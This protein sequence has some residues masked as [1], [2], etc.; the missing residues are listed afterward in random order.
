ME[1]G[2]IRNK[3]RF[4]ARYTLL[5]IAVAAPML[6]LLIVSGKTLLWGNDAF[7]QQ[8][9]VL[10][11]AS[12]AVRGLFSGGFEM[13]NL[14]LGQGMDQLLTLAY[15]GLTDPFQWLGA[16]FQG[17][18]LEIYYHAL[19]F[20]YIYLSGLYFML[21][22]R[23]I[24]LIRTDGWA[25]AIAGMVFAFCGY[26]TIGIIKN[27]YYAA[28]SLYLVLM[29]LAV[30]RVFQER[31]WLMMSLMTLLMLIS[32][33]YLAFQ[34]TLL[35]VI[36]IVIRLIARLRRVG[37]KRSAGDGF[38][39][40][41]SYL[42]G[43]MLSGAVLVPVAMNYLA[44]SRVDA[45]C[46]YTDSLLHY[47][48]AYYLKL[49][50]LFCAPYDYAGY[51]ALQS[52]CPLALFG[53]MLLLVR[54][55][56]LCPQ[57]AY[58]AQLRAGLAVGL[59]CL[60]I[61]LCGKLFNGMGYVTNRWCYGYAFIVC[62]CAA[63]AVPKLM[64]PAFAGRKR[65]ALGT[66]AWAA[67]MLVY[68][69]IAPRLPMMNG[70]GNAVAISG[71]SKFTKSLAAIAGALAVAAS[72]AALLWLDRRISRGR[73]NAMRALAWLTAACCLAY[74]IGYGFVAATSSEFLPQGVDARIES[75]T[76]AASRAIDDDSF[77]RVDSGINTDSHAEML[78]YRGT[79]YYWSLI[80]AWVAAHYTDLELS[81]QRWT[82]RVE[83]MGG[84]SY[85][86]ALADV[87]YALRPQRDG[88][89]CLPADCV[90]VDT[91]SLP[92]GSAVDIYENPNRLPLGYM[93]DSAMSADEYAAL[94]PVEKRQALISCA[95]LADENPDMPAW[96]GEFETQ[97]LDWQVVA[98]SGAEL[99]GNVLRG[100]AGGTLEIAFQ[101]APETEVY[102]WLEGTEL[103]EADD[104]TDLCLYAQSDAGTNR[105]YFI[106]PGGVFNYDQTGVCLRLGYS[107]T[108]LSSCTLRFKVTGALRFDAMQAVSVPAEYC[109]S[110]VE[111]IRADGL[112]NAEIGRDRASGM[113]TAARDGI[114][115]IALPYSSGWTA[116]VD[117]EAA[118]IF[119]CGGMYMG[120]EL[121]AGEHQ[122]EL[123]YETPGLRPGVGLSIAGALIAAVLT[124]LTRRRHARQG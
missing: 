1:R 84:D 79:S 25:L 54:R 111:H 2:R 46:G 73:G 7:Y 75:E 120:I 51:W 122:V 62:L 104:D 49:L 30:E 116:R 65:V 61:P 89:A 87:G 29:L 37:V 77:Y 58:R 83:G 110:A 60:C 48:A 93:F 108:G 86:S 3:S 40:L 43:L 119:R 42:L 88:V 28:G 85:L 57:D 98:S 12:A 95:V 33:F 31:K 97:A 26:Q 47:P 35:V 22:V 39:L 113:V 102:L 19:V 66:F 81:T 32:N 91:A 15:Y 92:N 63:W 50:A 100:E 24:R 101:A 96:N 13:L 56:R 118:Q 109:R 124:L 72:G 23:R 8:Y 82:F 70:A 69:A 59:V 74:S 38:I 21:Y 112:W 68:A 78:D 20:V 45:L 94:T 4:A 11:S 105:A 71:Y 67:L 36:Y 117:G 16:L 9:P 10:Y 103:L 107:E 114:L 17:R 123:S 14:S 80:P 6:L 64:E 41:G 53:V 27:P 5:Y 106:L 99:D 55:K 115:Q 121:S 18:A 76:A 34:T 52:F 44:S 90:L